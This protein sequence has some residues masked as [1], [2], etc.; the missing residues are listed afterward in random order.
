[1]P[2]KRYK[3]LTGIV[4]DVGI[5]KFNLKINFKDSNSVLIFNLILGDRLEKLYS[6]IDGTTG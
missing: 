3:H 5:L 6:V 2:A 4:G 1:M